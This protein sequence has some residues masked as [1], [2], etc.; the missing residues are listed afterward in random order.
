MNFHIET[1]R[2]ILRDVRDCDLEGMFELDSNPEVHKY[3]GNKPVKSRDQ[4][5]VYI[6]SI[7]SQYI[8]RGIGRF[9]IIEKASGDFMGWTGL[10]FNT[11]DNETLGEKRDFYDIGYR[12]IQRYWNKGY[13][14]ESAIAALDFGF[15]NLNIE[16]IVGAA[17]TENIASNKILQKIG[18]KHIEVFPYEDIMLNWYALKQKDY[19]A[20]NGHLVKKLL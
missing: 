2:L 3:L 18:L 19:E 11:G 10:K 5:Q 12:L 1:E 4:S 9:A 20:H 15:K 13:A 14:S 17:E 6:D 7:K 16:T 8:E